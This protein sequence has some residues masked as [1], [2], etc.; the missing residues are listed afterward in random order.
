M[1]LDFRNVDVL[2]L[3]IFSLPLYSFSLAANKY[4][5]TGKQIHLM[6]DIDPASNQTPMEKLQSIVYCILVAVC[7]AIAHYN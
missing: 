2:E 7:L 3:R 4:A 1:L 6:N 5:I